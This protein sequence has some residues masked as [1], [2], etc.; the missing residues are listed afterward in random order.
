M[1]TT[2]LTEETA[3]FIKLILGVLRSGVLDSWDGDD[4]GVKGVVLPTRK[5]VTSDNMG[6]AFWAT[7]RFDLGTGAGVPVGNNKMLSIP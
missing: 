6:G 7:V 5:G 2:F 4:D 1:L 3:T